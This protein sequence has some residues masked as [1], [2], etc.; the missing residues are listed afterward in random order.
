MN[1]HTH[2]TAENWNAYQQRTQAST[3]GQQTIAPACGF[4]FLLIASKL[5]MIFTFVNGCKTNKYGAER[6]VAL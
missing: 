2:N 1:K 4:F 3:K 5:R 6:Y